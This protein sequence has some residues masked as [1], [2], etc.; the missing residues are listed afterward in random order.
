VP[1]RPGEDAACL[2][3]SSR[4]RRELGWAP[5]IVLADGLTEVA[6]WVDEPWEEIAGL[7]LEYQHRP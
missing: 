6:A 7:P 2:L 4:A 1:E 3:D 5:T